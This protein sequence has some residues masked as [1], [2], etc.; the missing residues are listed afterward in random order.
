[1]ADKRKNTQKEYYSEFC[2]NMSS[3]D[4]EDSESNTDSDSNSNDNDVNMSIKDAQ[5]LDLLT[6]QSQGQ[7]ILILGYLLEYTASQQAIELINLKYAQKRY[8]EFQGVEEDESEEEEDEQRWK[9]QGIDADKTALLAAFLELYGQTILTRLDYIKF[10][11]FNDNTN[12]SD[13]TLSKTANWEIYTGAMLEELA[14][15]FNFQGAQKLFYISNQN[16]VLD[17]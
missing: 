8:D 6:T 14:Y 7:L 16:P 3:E 2:S 1:M 11:R 10:T 4:N 17:D 15:I 5:D 13:Y 9:N 12:D